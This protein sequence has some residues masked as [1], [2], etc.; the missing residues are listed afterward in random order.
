M[1]PSNKLPLSPKNNFGNLNME[2]LKHKKNNMGIKIIIKN[3]LIFSL[4]VKK[5]KIPS[6]EIVE[7]PST[8]SK[9][10]K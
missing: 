1:K 5:N 3:N 8:P 6:V 2:K 9:P 4:G 10:S 7:K